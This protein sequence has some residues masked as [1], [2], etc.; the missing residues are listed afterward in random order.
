[1]RHESPN[2]AHQTHT[3]MFIQLLLAWASESAHCRFLASAAATMLC[4][5]SH[6]LSNSMYMH[7]A[8]SPCPSVSALLLLPSDVS[9]PPPSG[10]F[11]PLPPG[12]SIQPLVTPLLPFISLR[13]MPCTSVF[14]S[15]GPLHCPLN[16]CR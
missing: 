16:P 1:M 12:A 7:L 8:S 9:P 11:L 4:Q 15:P 14:A 13:H 5:Y 10:I 2:L 3:D 6:Q